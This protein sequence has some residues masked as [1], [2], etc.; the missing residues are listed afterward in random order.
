MIDLHTHTTASDGRCAP[1]E[2]VA[3]AS[4]AGVRVLSVTDHDTVAGCDAAALACGSAGLEFVPGI[5]MTAVRDEVDTHILGYFID[6]TSE[7][8]HEFLAE[9]RR[10]RIDRVRQMIEKL[11]SFGI[12]LEADAI[13]QPAVEDPRKSAG[14]PWIARALVAGG[15]AATT[16]EAFAQWL[17]RGK[18]AFIARRGASPEEVVG[19]IHDAR[20]VASLAHPGLIG[21]DEWIESLVAAGLD[22]LEVYHTDHDPDDTARYLAMASRLGVAVTGGSDYHADETHGA[23]A[24]GIV[25]LPRE[26]YERLLRWATMRATASGPV[27]SS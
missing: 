15:H 19:R 27:T 16:D 14:R 24:P 8:L 26:A 17:G 11:A 4:A 13:L 18:P 2:L 20:G 21:H 25:S 1:A 22:A 5:E 7:G 3:R 9:Q 10:R 12:R 6:A 23:T